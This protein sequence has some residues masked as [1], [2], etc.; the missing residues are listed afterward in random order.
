MLLCRRARKKK[1][2][3]NKKLRAEVEALSIRIVESGALIIR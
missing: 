2:R 1:V 3:K